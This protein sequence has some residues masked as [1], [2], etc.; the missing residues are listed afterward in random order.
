MEKREDKT[1]R[2]GKPKSGASFLRSGKWDEYWETKVSH[3]DEHHLLMRGY[4]LPEIIENLSYTEALY[5]M[6]KGEL[7]D[8]K[9]TRVMNALLCGIMDYDFLS[10]TSTAG[11]LVAS[12]FPDSPI[13]GIAAGLLAIGRYTVSPQDA[14]ALIDRAYELM[15]KQNLTKE[16]IAK[17][18]VQEYEETKQR[19]PGFGHPLYQEVDPRAVALRKVAMEAGFWGEKSQ[20]YEA[21]H[22]EFEK[23]TGR[24]IAINID[25]M[26]ACVGDEMGFDPM[27]VAGIAAV[28]F[29]CGLIPHV[30]EEIKEGSPIRM[31]PPTMIKYAGSL[32]RHLSKR[33]KRLNR[34]QCK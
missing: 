19:I 1:V 15:R 31:V 8:E 16:Q 5:L 20:L 34:M 28:S 9:E 2:W 11:R 17:R 30:V 12:A 23:A 33:R 27:E 32:E 29:M 14:V 21:I 22:D 7:P 25:G 4:P 6:I 24:R 3:V 13:P 18:I 10:P 26:M